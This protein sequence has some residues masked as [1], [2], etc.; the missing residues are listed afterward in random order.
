LL[1]TSLA[2]ALLTTALTHI[3]ILI[4]HCDRLFL[5]IRELAADATFPR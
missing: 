5:A 4:C 1:A 2:A 3:L